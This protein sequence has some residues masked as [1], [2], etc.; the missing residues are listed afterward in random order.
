MP[1]DDRMAAFEENLAEWWE[2]LTLATG[3]TAD[4]GHG[5]YWSFDKADGNSGMH[6]VRLSP[7][8]FTETVDGCLDEACPLGSSV[9]A[10]VTNQAT[11]ADAV[12]RFKAMGFLHNKRYE[13]Y[14][15]DLAKLPEVKLSKGVEIERLSDLDR[16]SKT[17]AHPYH[18]PVTTKS[19]RLAMKSGSHMLK[20]RPEDFISYLLSIRGTPAST[21]TVFRTGLMAGVYDVG[22]T[23]D[24]RGKRYAQKLLTHALREAADDGV[25][26]AGLIAVARAEPLY[27]RIGFRPLPG[28]MSLMYF[29]KTRMRARAKSLGIELK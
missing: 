22:T 26:A 21:V 4:R 10:Y 18:G 23:E 20:E 24:M 14:V 25:K 7:E 17:V 1:A 13:V 16:F 27:Q 12:E 2:G 29:P 11:P 9:W 8:N 6:R 15:H 28:W 3:G 19:R 5:L